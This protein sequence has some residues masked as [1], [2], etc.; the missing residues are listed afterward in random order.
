MSK[1]VMFLQVGHSGFGISL[2]L[3][4]WRTELPPL[5]YFNI[6]S[7]VSKC[8][9]QYFFILCMFILIHLF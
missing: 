9:T 3:R 2:F 7:E 5:E 6:I 1:I 4:L 8:S